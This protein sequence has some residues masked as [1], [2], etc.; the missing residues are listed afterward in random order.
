MAKLSIVFSNFE[1][2]YDFMLVKLGGFGNFCPIKR[3]RLPFRANMRPPFIS[4]RF[5]RAFPQL[6]QL[7]FSCYARKTTIPE[8]LATCGNSSNSARIKLYFSGSLY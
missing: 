5:H 6:S 2:E 4:I 1:I 3:L 7:T 8:I